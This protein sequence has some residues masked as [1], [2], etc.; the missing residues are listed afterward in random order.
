MSRQSLWKLFTVPMAAL[1]LSGCIL[2]D[3]MSA[4]WD[5]GISDPCI[6]A[7]VELEYTQSFERAK[8]PPVARRFS[9]ED[10][11]YLMLKNAA[12][13]KGGHLYRFIIENG[14][15]VGYRPNPAMLKQFQQDYPDSV[16]QV[17]EDKVELADLSESSLALLRKVSAQDEYWVRDVKRMYNPSRKETCSLYVPREEDDED[18]N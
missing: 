2:V 13:D 18:E 15:Y 17:S 14:I 16:A 1:W 11:H 6:D 8:S 10:F 9:D 7:V 12:D 5:D 3:D 4:K